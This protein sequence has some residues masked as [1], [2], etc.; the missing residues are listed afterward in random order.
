MIVSLHNI[1]IYPHFA[2]GALDFL[3]QA[4][5]D[6]AYRD[7]EPGKI[8]Q[9]LRCGELARFKLIPHTPY[10]GTADA[11]PLY[12]IRLHA[13]WRAIGD[14]ALLKRKLDILEGCLSWID[15]YGDRDGDG[16]QEYQTRVGYENM[17]WVTNRK[18]HS[19][20]LRINLTRKSLPH[21]IRLG[22]VGTP[23]VSLAASVGLTIGPTINQLFRSRRGAPERAG[24]PRLKSRHS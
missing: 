8:F 16:F 6:D 14:A 13:A 17:S 11:T 21:P 20:K 3:G 24:L 5:E 12:L 9:E 15:N 19:S 10:Y 18:R 1:L 23:G 4:R 2:R 7:A 22:L